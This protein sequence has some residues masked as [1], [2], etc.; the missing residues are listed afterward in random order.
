MS[1]LPI[2]IINAH[3]ALACPPELEGRHALTPEQVFNEADAYAGDLFDFHDDVLHWI[4]FPYARCFLDVNR[5]NDNT[6]VDHPALWRAGDGI[7]KRQTSYGVP[8]FKPGQQP[9]AREEQALIDTHW[10]AWHAQLEA[11]ANDPRVKL[12]FDCHSMAAHGPSH[13]SDPGALRPRAQVANLGDAN[14]EVEALRGMLSAPAA[15]TRE[16][17]RLLGDAMARLDTLVSAGE[18]CRI[19]APFWGGWNVWGHGGTRQP[20]LMIEINR[21]LYVGAQHSD[22]PVRPPDHPR[23]AAIRDAIWGAITLLTQSLR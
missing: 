22:A 15:M 5:P 20:W 23:I 8:V 18:P 2:A 12:V 4:S 1:R 14:A 10:R 6:L 7:V 19:N 11:V 13:Y 16:F 21:A 3:G 17:S 9:D